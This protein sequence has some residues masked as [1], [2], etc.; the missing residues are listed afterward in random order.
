MVFITAGMG[1][2]TGTGAAPV[3]A[4]IARDMGMLTVA[5][6]TKPFS[7]EGAK[8]ML[9]ANNGIKDLGKYVDSLITI[10]NDKLLQ[11]LGKGV[12]LLDAFKAA[13]DVLLG[14][15]QGIAELIT[16]PGS[17]QRRLRRR[18]Y[19]DVGDGHGDDGFGLRQ[20]RRPGT[21]RGRGGDRQSVAGRCESAGRA[22]A[23]W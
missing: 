7:F 13:N 8:R 1:G 3:V 4:Q 11:V 12:S 23:S 20:R 16:R 17:D 9:I 10:P 5:V 2:G 19:R 6:V 15:V 21:A 18:A 22:A 14:A